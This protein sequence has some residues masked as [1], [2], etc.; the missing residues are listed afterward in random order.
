MC[1]RDRITI[2]HSGAV[3]VGGAL[4]SGTGNVDI[5]STGSTITLNNTIKATSGQVS[6]DASS[7]TTVADAGDITTTTGQVTFG[8]SRTGSLSAS[9]DVTTS[10]GDVKFSRS[11]VL[12]KDVSINTGITEGAISFYLLAHDIT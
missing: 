5:D 4:S 1:I 6:I 7:K 11:M 2:D 8:A 3:K 12:G 10:G 9:G